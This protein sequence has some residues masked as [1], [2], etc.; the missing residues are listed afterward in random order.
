[1]I[2]SSLVF[3]NPSSQ[4]PLRKNARRFRLRTPITSPGIGKRQAEILEHFVHISRF[5]NHGVFLRASF[6][7]TFPGGKD[8]RII[9][10]K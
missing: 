10:S 5:T 3:F 1:M 4:R 7:P 2:I 9:R 8:A 6:D